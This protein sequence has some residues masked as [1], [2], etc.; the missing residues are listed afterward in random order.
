L[1]AG[2]ARWGRRKRG[3]ESASASRQSYLLSSK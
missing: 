3:A 1:R 2:A